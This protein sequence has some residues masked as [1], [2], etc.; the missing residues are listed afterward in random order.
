[1]TGLNKII[2]KIISEA[3]D[4]ARITVEQA[5]RQCI[6]ISNEYAQMREREKEALVKE[7]EDSA[8]ELILQYKA[9]AEQDKREAIAKAKDDIVDRVFVMAKEHIKTLPD[10]KY[11]DIIGHLA[12]LALT[13][14]LDG[15]RKSEAELKIELLL[16]EKDLQR[17]GEGVYAVLCKRASHEFG[18]QTAKRIVLSQQ[19]ASIFGGVVVR[20]GNNETRATFVKLFEGL[21]EK[22]AGEIE[23]YLFAEENK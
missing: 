15:Q 5:R 20:C 9:Q 18:K 2:E 17:C 11:A 1:M 19:V 3:H 22:L 4:R 8:K 12:F 6:E 23:G 10:E 7:A 21:R 16:T 14:L 13:E